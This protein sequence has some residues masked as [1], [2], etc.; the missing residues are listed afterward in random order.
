MTVLSGILPAL[1]VANQVE[2]LS[3]P[4]KGDELWVIPSAE[5]GLIDLPRL[6]HLLPADFAE[7]K[8]VEWL[9][10]ADSWSGAWI[11]SKAA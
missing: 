7:A 5:L 1:P 8:V 4:D 9:P 3:V 2:L 11:L 6:R 10:S